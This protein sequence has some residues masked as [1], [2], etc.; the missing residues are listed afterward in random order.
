MKLNTILLLLLVL[1]ISC[2]NDGGKNDVPLTS[3]E[4]ELEMKKWDSIYSNFQEYEI[5]LYEE[6]NKNPKF[7]I[8]KIDSL[9]TVY[10]TDANIKA[11]LHYFKG[12]VF[13]YLGEHKKSIQELTFE[14]T[15]ETE[16]GLV[17]NY[18]KLKKFQKS[19][20]ILNSISRNDINF[21]DYI[22]A[23]Y[24]E[25]IGEKNQALKLYEDIKNDKGLKRFF[26]YQLAIRRIIELKKDKPLLLNSIYFPTGNP[27]FKENITNGL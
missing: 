26:Y 11:D 9:L 20:Q 14:N 18:I 7:V 2:K 22:Y 10:K 25:V 19:K 21:A 13:Y 23:N 12:E 6:Y 3:Y 16:I 15:R 8:S 17:C 24:Y 27:N 1:S 4:D 5:K